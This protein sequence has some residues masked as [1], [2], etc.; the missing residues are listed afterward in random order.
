[1][2][3]AT[4]TLAAR[5]YWRLQWL[6]HRSM[7][8]VSAMG[9]LA[10]EGEGLVIED[11]ILARQ[12]VSP[13]HV[14]LDMEWWADKQVELFDER[15][16]EPWR[17]SV[18]A[19][20]HPAGL[21]RPSG[22]DEQTMAGGFGR[23]SFAIMLIL[24]RDGR[25]YARMD[26]DHDFGAGG[27][28]RLSVPC[29]VA[30]DWG[31]AGGEPVTPETLAAWE[32][33]FEARVEEAPEQGGWLFLEDADEERGRR[34]ACKKARKRGAA[35]TGAADDHTTEEVNEYV[36]ACHSQGLDPEAP[37]VFEQ[38]FGFGPDGAFGSGLF[39]SH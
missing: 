14:S 16:I 6:C 19:H 17:T 36:A 10:P 9:L 34:R 23:W 30:I 7:N 27:R 33:E 12:E 13:A 2:N 3:H 29:R 5:A 15:G 24:T 38:F 18:W 1:M 11:F 35:R 31:R 20:T 32:E 22:V 26:V 8:E 25:F 4:I 37:E 39:G 21:D 28:Q